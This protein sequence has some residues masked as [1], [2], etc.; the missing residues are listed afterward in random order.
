MRLRRTWTLHTRRTIAESSTARGRSTGFVPVRSCS[1][2]LFMR[3]DDVLDRLEHVALELRIVAMAL[4]VAQEQRELRD[5]VLQVV[6]DERRHAVERVE[7]AR[8]EQ[9]VARRAPARGSSPPGG[10]PS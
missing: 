5:E 4:G 6:H 2:R 1:M 9:R 7:L 10:S 3:V 8:L